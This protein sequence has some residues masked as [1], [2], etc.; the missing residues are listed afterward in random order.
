MKLAPHTRKL[1][2][3]SCAAVLSLLFGAAACGEEAPLPTGMAG[4]GSVIPNGGTAGTGAEAGTGTTSMAGT[5]TTAGS[6][7]GGVPMTTGGSAGASTGGMSASGSG[8]TSGSGGSAAG[9]AT[10]GGTTGGSGGGAPVDLKE[11][12]GG[13]L[14]GAMYLGACG[15]NSN[16]T[17]CQTGGGMACPA[18]N[19]ADPPLGGKLT[20]DKT[21]T[22]G[23]DPTKTYTI[24]LHVQ[25]EVEAKGYIN[26]SDQNNSAAHPKMDGFYT[27]GAPQPGDDYNIYMARVSAPKQDYFLN[28]IKPPG[29]TDH[30]TYLIDYSAKIKANGGAT[31]RMTAADTNCSMIKN[32]GPTPNG[33]ALCAQ[34]LVMQNMDPVAVS[35]N[36]SF[37]FSKAY[38][39]QWIVL[40]VTD[41]VQD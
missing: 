5:G 4:T 13:P 40:V 9:G 29:V 41:V 35:K 34:P 16:Q 25:G 31:I 36:P 28:A 11:T 37:D 3:L 19:S 23:G 22:L 17:V 18:K 14:N 32:C 10:G 39:G 20:T 8:G 30:T 15:T 2:A 12:V 6:G 21:I 27:G 38:N 24:T 33:T 7:T 26:G 1:P